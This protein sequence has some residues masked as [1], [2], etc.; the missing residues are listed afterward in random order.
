MDQSKY[1]F[2]KISELD[3]P[4]DGLCNNYVD[5]YWMVTEDEEVMFYGGKYKSPQC[6]Y[7]KECAEAVRKNLHPTCEVRQLPLIS[8]P[9]NPSDY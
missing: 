9:I 5:C 6:N 4:K 2:V 7:N 3:K 8:F 1:A